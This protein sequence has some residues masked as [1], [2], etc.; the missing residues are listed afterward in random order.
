MKR[1]VAALMVSVAIWATVAPAAAAPNDPFFGQQWALQRVGAEFAWGTTRGAGVIIA[2]VDSG[3]DLTHPDLTGRILQGKDFAD[4]DDDPM[5]QNGHGTL[6]AGIAAATTDN[7]QGVASV[8]PAASM[9]PVRAFDAAGNG[10]ADHVAA[11]IDWAVQEA[12]NRGLPLVLNLSF[13]QANS[14]G[15]PINLFA[16]PTLDKAIKDAAQAGAAVFI[17]AGNDGKPQTA[18]DS[19]SPG[20]AVVGASDKDDKRASLSNHGAGLDILAPGIDIVSTYRDVDQGKSVYASADGTSASVPFVAGAAALLMS[21]G[22]TNAQAI[23]RIYDTAKDLGLPGRDDDTGHGLLDVAAALGVPRT[24]PSP[25]PAGRS[26][27]PKPKTSPS[28]TLVILPSPGE[29]P[30]IILPATSPRPSPEVTQAAHTPPTLPPRLPPTQVIA[31]MLVVLVSGGHIL[32]R[33]YL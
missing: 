4:N 30:R 29:P 8:A 3:I 12:Q 26:P 16:D 31:V 32:Y 5:D 24:S 27:T 10:T 13:V 18:Y 17:A 25:S 2:S 1:C 22:K 21:Q 33:L 15:T 9:L 23:Q 19:T 14:E 7:G 11:G 28:P 20:I 6:I